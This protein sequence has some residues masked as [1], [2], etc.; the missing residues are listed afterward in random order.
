MATSPARSRSNP[1]P[2]PP[3]FRATAGLLLAFVLVVMPHP[4]PQVPRIFSIRIIPPLLPPERR[5][6][7]KVIRPHDHL[8]AAAISR[9]RVIYRLAVPQ[10]GAQPRLLAAGRI[11]PPLRRVRP[12]VDI[13]VL[14]RPTAFVERH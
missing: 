11:L 13:V 8:Q 10:E 4:L 5:Q 1:D 7:Q 14:R 9:I 2:G 3:S 6:V 12:L